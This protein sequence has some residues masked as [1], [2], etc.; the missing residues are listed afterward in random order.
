MRS[1]SISIRVLHTH[2]HAILTQLTITSGHYE[3]T[4]KKKAIFCPSTASKIWLILRDK[5]F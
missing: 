3:K 4:A 1:Y 5:S 2:I